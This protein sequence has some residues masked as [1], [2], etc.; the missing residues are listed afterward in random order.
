MTP[1]PSLDEFR[2]RARSGSDSDWA[3]ID[4]HLTPEYLTAEYVAQAI[5]VDLKDTDDNIR[6]FGATLTARSDVNIEYE[7]W[8][9]LMGQMNSDPHVFVRQWIANALYKRRNRRGDVVDLVQQTA[10]EKTPAGE[11]AKKLLGR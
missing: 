9:R 7:D 10:L 1:A 4:E 5:E 8:I 6:D 11:F 2:A 3:W